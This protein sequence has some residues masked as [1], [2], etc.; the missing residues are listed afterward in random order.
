MLNFKF[1]LKLKLY[2]NEF[3]TKNF[4]SLT[5]RIY[6]QMWKNVIKAFKYY[7]CQSEEKI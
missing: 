7:F 5:K 1:C 4:S 3:L 2:S 6:S